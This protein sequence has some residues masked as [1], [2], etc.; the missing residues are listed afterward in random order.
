RWR[1]PQ[2]HAGEVLDLAFIAENRLASIGSD[3]AERIWRLDVP[4]PGHELPVTGRGLVSLAASPDGRM[5]AAADGHGAIRVWDL[6][7]QLVWHVLAPAA[8]I[9]RDIAF[10]A[11]AASIVTAGD[12]G[13][14]L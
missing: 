11:D 1:L 14:V 8:A 3:G 4:G 6:E 7:G 12:D 2:A 13:F 10:T 5:L 9:I